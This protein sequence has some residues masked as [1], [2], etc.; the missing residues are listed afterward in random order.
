MQLIDDL[1][2]RD[3]NI[4]SESTLHLVLR[5][6]GGGGGPPPSSKYYKEINIKFIKGKDNINFL[7]MPISKKEEDLYGLLNLCWLKEIAGKFDDKSIL[8]LPELLSSIIHLLKNGYVDYHM[9]KD[10]IKH[11]L[12]KMEGNNILNFSR[13]IEKIIDS[14]QKQML[15][16]FLNKEDL[17][18]I[19]DIHARLLNYNEHI[20]LFEKD[21]EE[22]KRQS[23][24]E[25]SVISLVI[26][27]REDYHFF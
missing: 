24:F 3:Y 13:Y 8:K 26:M 27:E 22:R 4:P 7:F 21:F 10:E 18:E 2:L 5:I 6:R 23:I 16:Q 19:N 9:A 20:K 15:L 14:G 12:Y 1:S 11:I 25:F 17:N